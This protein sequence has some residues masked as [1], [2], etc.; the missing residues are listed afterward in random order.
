MLGMLLLFISMPARSQFY[1]YGQDA[2]NLRWY[3][4]KTEHYRFI[5]PDGIDSL[6]RAYAVRAEH[7]YPY[8]GK[9]LDHNHSPMPVIL[10]N[11][12]S[13]SNGV[14]VWAPKRLEIF[15]N[16]DP[17]GYSQDWLTQLA[18]HE[19]RHAVQIDKLDQGFTR[20]LSV[21]GG[22]QMVG[23]MAVFLPLWYLEG[24]AVDSETRLSTSGRGR[25]PAFE[26]ELKAQLLEADRLWSFSKAYM[27]SFKDHV[28]NHYQLGYFMV[29]HGRSTYGDQFW[30]DFQQYAARKPF[31]L[32]PTWFAMKNYGFSSKKQFYEEALGA[33]RTHWRSMSVERKY[34]PEAY[35]SP[36]PGK[37]YTSYSFP[38][39]IS[40]NKLLSYKSGMDQIPEIV[41]ID[42]EGREERVFRPG[43]LNSGRLSLSGSLIAWDE[44]IPDTRWSNR[45]FSVIKTY[46]MET[47]KRTSLG[48]KTRYYSPDLS[49]DAK[50]LVVIEQNTRGVSSLVILNTNGKGRAVIPAPVSG[51]LQHPSWMEKDSAL[52]V[53]ITDEMGK[54]LYRYSLLT[55]SWYRILDAGYDQVSQPDVSDESIYFSGTF[56]GINNIYCYNSALDETYQLSSVPFG[57][58][59]PQLSKDGKTL[60]YSSYTSSGHRLA[61]MEM[62]DAL[63]KPLDRAKDH[64]EQLDYKQSKAEKELSGQE[65][66]DTLRIEPKAYRK[67]A[68][69]FNVHS[70]LP[71][72]VDYLNPSL[73]LNPEQLP[74][75][76]GFSLISQ[77]HLS[78]VVSQLAYEYS[79]GYHYLHTG[80]QMKGRYPVLNLYF[81]YGGEPEVYKF[82]DS[83]SISVLPT[84][85]SFNANT[86]IPFRL[87]TGK[88]LS[89]IQP[90]INYRYS[91]DIQF[92]ENE[93]GYKEGGHYLY[94][95]LYATSYLRTGKRDILPRFG[96]SLNGGYYHSPFSEFFGAVA[97][98]KASIYLPGILKHQSLKLS[99]EHQQQYFKSRILN[100]MNMPRGLDGIY[101]EKM[102]MFS[103]DYVFP[104]LYPDLAL[105]PVL[106]L[107][108]IRATLWTDYLIGH[109]V[110]IPDP[111]PHWADKNYMTYGVELLGDL[112]ILR[113]PFTLSLGGRFFYNP[114]NGTWG[115]ESLATI[116]IP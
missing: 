49:E 95:T 19:S 107:K 67:M 76:L 18:L 90:G 20:V 75:S 2:G 17:N 38:H 5:Y 42:G 94:Y 24:D 80:V 31:L 27:G 89:L 102:S 34:T 1:E 11:E 46:D 51:Y 85:I 43:Y 112:N 53:F 50:R 15:T 113:I 65:L 101:G 79:E 7:Y 96:M 54:S 32:N 57:A 82:R 13:F 22:E 81:D 45:N 25:L 30:I 35:L 111:S 37:H 23:A 105:G 66:V 16:P 62:K 114:E 72:Y 33:Y 92:Y 68:H 108:R 29:R 71:L 36:D 12:T 77:N 103:A 87:N 44:F 69:L 109:N 60:Y 21:L 39:C 26:M 10:H 47:G 52:V 100:L 48:K 6:A 58:F 3:Q 106:Y 116:D 73:S 63:W 104:V 41:T 56:S 9:S 98:A 97:Y 64:R 4:F 61:S 40:E 110:F 28:P 59:Q 86:Y 115:L 8:I 91:R 93:P 55:D 99:V 74:V 78:T 88:F 14:F 84:N 83:D 70:W